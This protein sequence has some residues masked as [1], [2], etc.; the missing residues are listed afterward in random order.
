MSWRLRGTQANR[1]AADRHDWT[2]LM[3]L[4]AS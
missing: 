2:S 4:G 1:A 3:R